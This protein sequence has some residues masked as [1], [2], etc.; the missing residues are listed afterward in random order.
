MAGER[1][2]H[3]P[4]RPRVGKMVEMRTAEAKMVE[5]RMA[6]Y[7]NQVVKVETTGVAVM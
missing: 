4:A 7:L 1:R 6:G 2:L 3:S 5:A